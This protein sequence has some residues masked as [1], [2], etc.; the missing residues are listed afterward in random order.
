MTGLR[1]ALAFLTP[2][3]VGAR[4]PGGSTLAWFPVAGAVLG[5]LVGGAWWLAGEVCPP[6]VAA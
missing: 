2:L 3:P 4:V 5:L 1:G 6:A